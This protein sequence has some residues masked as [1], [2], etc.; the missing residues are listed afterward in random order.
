MPSFLKDFDLK[1]ACAAFVVT[2]SM[3]TLNVLLRYLAGTSL[4]FSEE[5]AYL[6]FAHTVFFGAA[7]LYRQRVMIAVE[8]VVDMMSPGLRHI[9]Q[10]A[11]LV[12]LLVTNAYMTYIA[13]LLASDGWV[14]RTAY[15]EIPYVWIHSAPVFGFALMAIYS[16]LML[17]RVLRGEDIQYAEAADQK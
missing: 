11:S 10:L 13:A 3:V 14:R 2:I 4:L 9:N 7:Y 6:G 17:I 15:L 8:F 12:L 5:I 1:V 16:A